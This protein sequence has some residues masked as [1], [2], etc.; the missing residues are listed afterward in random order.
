MGTVGTSQVLQP[1]DEPD[2]GDDEGKELGLQVGCRGGMRRQAGQVQG[3][4][5][6]LARAF[7][8]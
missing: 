4:V 7:I 5:L 6:L 1:Q 2:S 8:E 3:A